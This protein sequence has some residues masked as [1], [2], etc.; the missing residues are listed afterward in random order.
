MTNRAIL[1]VENR[2]LTCNCKLLYCVISTLPVIILSIFL[3]RNQ[4]YLANFFFIYDFWQNSFI[5][6]IQTKHQQKMGRCMQARQAKTN[7][8][9]SHNS[10]KNPS[11]KLKLSSKLAK[12]MHQVSFRNKTPSTHI[13]VLRSKRKKR[14]TQPTI[15][16]IEN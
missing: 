7:I 9:Q 6:R 2:F 8:K 12:E 16:N 13:M 10:K 3:S 1:L 15:W 5:L 11:M 14:S 4:F